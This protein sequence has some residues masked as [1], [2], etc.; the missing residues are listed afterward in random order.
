MHK[1]MKMKNEVLSDCAKCFLTLPSNLSHAY[2]FEISRIF[3]GNRSIYQ[4]LP[5][6]RYARA[7]A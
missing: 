6:N 4:A 5:I 7:C 3:K 2:C 1:D